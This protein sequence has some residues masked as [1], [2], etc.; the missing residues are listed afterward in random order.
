MDTP[1]SLKVSKS[2]VEEGLGRNH[3]SRTAN[4]YAQKLL[5]MD[6]N[7]DGEISLDELTQAI[8][9]IV[10]TEKKNRLL[11]WLAIA[12]AVFCVLTVAATV[13]LVVAVVQLSK[14]TSVSGNVLVSKDTNEAL[15]KE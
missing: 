5:S 3:S 2:S 10:K 9:E 4:R 8:D 15:R 12:L 6:K 1:N 11:K 14:D 13:G 7:G